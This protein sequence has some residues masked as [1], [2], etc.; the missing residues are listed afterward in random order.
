MAAAAGVFNH[1]STKDRS[2]R[3]ELRQAL[4]D[5]EAA[6]Y[7]RFALQDSPEMFRKACVNVVDAL[8]LRKQVARGRTSARADKK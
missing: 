6:T 8:K 4:A 2:Y 7:L 3:D 1:M 5:P